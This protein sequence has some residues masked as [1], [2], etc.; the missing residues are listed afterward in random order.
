M[1]ILTLALGNKRDA[2]SP[3]LHVNLQAYVNLCSYDTSRC[4]SSTSVF[5]G[6]SRTRGS[7]DVKRLR[8]GRGLPRLFRFRES[9]WTIWCNMGSI[10]RNLPGVMFVKDQHMIAYDSV[11]ITC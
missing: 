4:F 7:R 2:A 1:C 8:K 11:M 5:P 3:H 9:I 6:D 10:E